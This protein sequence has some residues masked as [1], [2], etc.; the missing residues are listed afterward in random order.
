MYQKR[1]IRREIEFDTIDSIG[2]LSCLY[3]V[4]L[5]CITINLV[6][7]IVTEKL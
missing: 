2:C 5:F 3:F 7:G 6:S 1:D 4:E